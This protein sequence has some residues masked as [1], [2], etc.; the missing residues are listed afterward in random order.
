[1]T[2]LNIRESS[3]AREIFARNF[4]ALKMFV[5][6]PHQDEFFKCK[7]TEVLARGG[8]RSGK[9]T[10]AAVRFAATALDRPVILSNG[11]SCDQRLSW[12]KDR[13]LL[14]WVIGYQDN[15]IG[16]TIYRLLFRGG[17]FKIIRD[18]NTGVWRA[19]RPWDPLDQERMQEVKPSPPLIPARYIKPGRDGWSFKNKGAREFEVC[20][21]LNGTEIYAFPS[22][23]EPKAGDPVDEIWIDESIKYPQHIAEWQARLSDRRGRLL[24]S[25]WPAQS[26]AGLR[27]MSDRAKEYEELEEESPPVR[28]FVFR[29]SDNPFISAE[30]KKERLEAWDE[31]ERRA[32]DLGEFVTDQLLVYPR[33][34]KLMHCAYTDDESEDDALARVLRSR[35][36]EPPDDWT[37]ELILD[38]GTSR[39]AV[40]MCAVPPPSFGDFVV[41]Y[42]EVY[43]P[44]LDADQLAD[45]VRVKSEGYVFERFIIDGHAA[46]TKP[47]GFG[48]TIGSN[49]QRAFEVRGLRSRKTGS[50]FTPGSDDVL[51]RIGM[52]QS[53][54]NIRSDGTTKLRIVTHRCQN[55][56]EQFQSYYKTQHGDIVDEKPAA[57]QKNDVITCLEYWASRLP[58]Y[59]AVENRPRKISSSEILYRRLLRR[60]KKAEDRTIYCGIGKPN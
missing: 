28:E 11:D 3:A 19:Y 4:E 18:Q 25:S 37:R 26:N 35:N 30:A 9:S 51:G 44:R 59:V 39:P 22:T 8:N 41:P 54:L 1:M 20:R 46:R 56:V 7:S 48:V 10:V 15:H 50:N 17:L 14:M 13:P 45:K 21:L 60:K 53:W 43:I 38:P 52:V 29:F 33:F 31:D 5:A 23:G 6:M 2:G 27:R 57:R 49:Y 24:W 36:G 32:R 40:L 42:D 58:E 16:Q 12:Q 55:L 34:N 47:M